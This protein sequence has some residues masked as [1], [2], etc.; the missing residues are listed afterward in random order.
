MGAPS[1]RRFLPKGW[2]SNERLVH[3]FIKSAQAFLLAIAVCFS[4]GAGSFQ[5]TLTTTSAIA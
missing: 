3:F 4:L 5:R 2:E 1:V